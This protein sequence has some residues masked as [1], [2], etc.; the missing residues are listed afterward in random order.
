MSSFPT[1]SPPPK[2]LLVG[3]GP[4]VHFEDLEELAALA[5]TRGFKVVGSTVQRFNRPWSATWIGPGKVAEIKEIIEQKKIKQ[6]ILDEEVTPAQTRNLQKA[7]SIPVSDRSRLILEIFALHAQTAEA[8]RQVEL[9]HCHYL[10]PRLTRMWC[11]LD[12]QKGG[13]TMRGPG[14]KELETDRRIVKQR[15]V[16]LK[17]KLLIIER[18][19]NCQRQQKQQWINAALVGYTNAGK[20]TLMQRLTKSQVLVADQLFATLG[21]TVRKSVIAGNPFL[22]SDTVGFIRNLPSSLIAS[23]RSTLAAVSQADLLL[24]VVNAAHPNAM[25]QIEVVAATLIKINA[26]HIKTLLVLNKQDQLKGKNPDLEQNITHLFSHKLKLP[27]PTIVWSSG[28]TPEGLSALRKL[29]GQ[30]VGNLLQK[31][32][33]YFLNQPLLAP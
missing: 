10:L 21:N 6:V 5:K 23:F 7:W 8:K 2:V 14:E 26:A 17:K 24:H 20:S 22:L 27:N 25:M 9:A 13:A 32:Y 33:S 4:R 30:I 11:H 29:L 19:T 3:A 28:T 12:R 1:H 31:R 18:Q 15:I 16:D